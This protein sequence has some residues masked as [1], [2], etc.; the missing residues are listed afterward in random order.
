MLTIAVLMAATRSFAI[1]CPIH[2][3]TTLEVDRYAKFGDRYGR[4][5]HSGAAGLGRR[6]G[7]SVGG[8]PTDRPSSWAQI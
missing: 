6:L 5:T 1:V 4:Y 3:R 8:G 2:T 7:R